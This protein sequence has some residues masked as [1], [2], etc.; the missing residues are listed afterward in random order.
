MFAA[1]RSWSSSPSWFFRASQI[2]SPW[3]LILTWRKSSGITGPRRKPHLPL[4]T[5]PRF[6]P[7]LP[8][9]ACLWSLWCGLTWSSDASLAARV[10]LCPSP[11]RARSSPRKRVVFCSS[12]VVRHTSGVPVPLL[13]WS[14]LR[15][16]PGRLA[17]VLSAVGSSPS[18]CLAY[19]HVS[20]GFG[21]CAARSRHLFCV[22]PRLPSESL[23]SLAH[24]HYAAPL[25]SSGLLRGSAP[26]APCFAA[27]RSS[28]FA[29][30]CVCVRMCFSLCYA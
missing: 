17:T 19:P 25:V 1:T 12:I 6:A 24:E 14:C 27:I 10:S 26:A 9:P 8:L 16:T 22:R 15:S 28:C 30:V 18:V 21:A 2:S 20:R 5:S 13:P 7:P 11:S 4:S 29:F 23:W 3:C